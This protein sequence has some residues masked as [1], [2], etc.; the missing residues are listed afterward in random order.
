MKS[1]IGKTALSR[2]EE[3]I[4]CEEVITHLLD[5]LSRELAPVEEREF[6]RHLEIC[7]SCVGYLKSYLQTVRL[8]RIA[9][10]NELQG[11]PPELAPELVHA[12]LSSR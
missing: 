3:Y 7:P 9:M 12:I 8:G 2:G 5:Y 1:R 6:E 4:T 11:P 10:Q